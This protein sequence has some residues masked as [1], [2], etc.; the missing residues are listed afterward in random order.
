MTQEVHLCK[1]CGHGQCHG[2]ADAHQKKFWLMDEVKVKQ[3]HHKTVVALDKAML[4]QPIDILLDGSLIPW[5]S[6]LSSHFGF[7][8]KTA[9]DP[10]NDYPLGL[11]TY[12][13]SGKAQMKTR[14]NKALKRISFD[15]FLSK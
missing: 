12:H 8:C 10:H 9:H 6:S 15:L 1:I 2:A 4:Q 11:T 5:H 7:I 14:E 3:L 13:F